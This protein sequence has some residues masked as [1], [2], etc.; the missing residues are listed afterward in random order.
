MGKMRSLNA[1]LSRREAVGFVSLVLP[2]RNDGRTPE[3]SG[4]YQPFAR[5]VCYLL[6]QNGCCPY[7]M[8]LSRLI[9]EE[10][11]RRPFYGSRKMVIIRPYRQSQ[12]GTTSDAAAGVGRHGTG[13]EHQ[14][15][16]P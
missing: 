6:L 16:T 14:S 8:L 5:V 10:Y 3:I 11:T 1:G 7:F 2:E 9:D 12:A 13:A 4:D 15:R